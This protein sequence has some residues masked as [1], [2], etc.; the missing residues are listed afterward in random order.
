MP[1][2]TPPRN[3]SKACHGKCNKIKVKFSGKE[4]MPNVLESNLFIKV[5]GVRSKRHPCGHMEH[6]FSCRVTVVWG[7]A[8]SR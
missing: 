3:Y 1:S 7:C 4:K 2:K 6:N 5:S 8:T